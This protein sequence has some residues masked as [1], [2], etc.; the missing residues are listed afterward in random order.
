MRPGST[1]CDDA[2]AASTGQAPALRAPACRPAGPAAAGI[3]ALP[4]E[5]QKAAIRGMV[6]GLAARLAQNG[7]DP[8]GWLRLVRAYTVLGETDK[9]RRR[10]PTPGAP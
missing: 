8:E 7:H 9:A 1:S 3:A 2:L 10:W 5:Q 4:P 6:D